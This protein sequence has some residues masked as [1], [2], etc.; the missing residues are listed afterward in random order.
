[1]QYGGLAENGLLFG[2]IWRD[3]VQSRMGST[4]A[5]RSFF[6]PPVTRHILLPLLYTRR[7]AAAVCGSRSSPPRLTCCDTVRSGMISA[8]ALLSFDPYIT[9]LRLLLLRWTQWYVAAAYGARSGTSRLT[10]CG[11]VLSGTVSTDTRRRSTLTSLD[12]DCCCC[13]IRDDTLPRHVDLARVR[14]A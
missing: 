7:H 1:M 13:S 14:L 3:T 2:L 11:T 8:N 4:A 6:D 9:R 5:R 10:R 12:A